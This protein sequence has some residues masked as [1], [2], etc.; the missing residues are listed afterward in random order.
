MIRFLGILFLIFSIAC[1]SQD[2]S[3]TTQQQLEDL[4]EANVEELNDDN[5]LQQLDYFRKHPVNLNTASVE[6]LQSLGWITDLQISNLVRYRKLFGNLID[7]YELQAVPT[8]DLV[9]IKRILPYV[10]VIHAVPAKENFRSRLHYGDQS[11]LFRATRVLERSKGYDASANTH[12]LGDRNHL[13]FRYRYQYKDL[14][15]F[16]VTGDKDAGEPF[17]RG[18]QSKG[19]DFYSF[20]FF[21][22]RLGLIRSLALGDYTV[23]FGQGL[24]QWQSLAFGKSADILSIKRQAPVLIPYRSAGE[25]YFNRG[26]GITLQKRKMGAT[27][28]A[29]YKKI[30][31]NMVR[32]TIERFTSLLTSGYYRTSSEIADRN[33]ITLASF[34]G[35]LSYQ[36]S[37][38]KIG[39]NAVA[40]HFSVPLQKREEPYNLFA[41]NGKKVFNSSIDYGYTYKNMHLFGEAAIDKNLHKAVVSGA[42]ISVDPKVD[43]SVL[44]RHIQK[45]YSSL[46]GNA[47]T[48]N[49]T[50]VNEKGFYAGIAIRPVTEWQVNAYADFFQF[51]WIKY[52]VNAPTIGYDYLIQLNYKPNKQSGMYVRYKNKNKPVDRSGDGI[53]NY[54]QD[55][56]KQDLRV[57]L[58]QQLS[59]V[60]SISSR[61]ELLWWNHPLKN[62]E[63][64][65]LSYVEG[66]AA[67]KKI[68]A[69][70]RLQYFE[71]DSYNS[72][73]YVYESDVLYSFSIPAF[74]DKGFRYY[75]NLHY[76]VNKKLQSW[77]RLGQ[78]IY[79]NKNVI[80]SGLDQIDGNKRV[81]ARIQAAYSF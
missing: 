5:L 27:V 15:Y 40:H 25:F 38:F 42:L 14:L 12:Y 55:E 76:K 41:I 68:S 2:V 66:N 4:A 80:G 7:I 31:G 77:L 50:P 52:G 8:W 13:L 11:L 62:G 56:V 22:R 67:W 74:Y 33:K 39:F 51:P 60:F 81:E 48:E 35:N 72:R 3:P 44:Y 28:F 61:V 70:L 32:D 37:S 6:E 65:F 1:Y 71:T 69:N 64:G 30:S 29:S 24:I 73:I 23:N 57:H 63:Q 54:P 53:I 10:T 75:V 20:H 78:T 47:F 36:T 59:P 43:L 17:F 19:F 45:E 46:F 58:A 34:G 21:A 9:T 16:G 49:T 79:P 18:A 26:I